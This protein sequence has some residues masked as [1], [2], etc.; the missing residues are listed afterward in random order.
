MVQLTTRTQPHT[1]V[2]WTA[3]PADPVSIVAVFSLP[4]MWI[5]GLLVLRYRQRRRDRRGS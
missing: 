1:L 3:L 5:G 2:D 4:A